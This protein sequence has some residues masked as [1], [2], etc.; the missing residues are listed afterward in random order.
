MHESCHRP[1]LEREKEEEDDGSV[2]EGA[3]GGVGVPVRMAPP[4]GVMSSAWQDRLGTTSL[5]SSFP[6]SVC[7]TR[8]SPW[9]LVAKSSEES[10]TG[11]SGVSE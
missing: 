9:L 3:S 4:S 10:L 1:K 6:V 5:S 7:H 2:R 11:R 8:T